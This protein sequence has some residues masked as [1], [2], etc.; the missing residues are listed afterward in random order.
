[1]QRPYLVAANEG[2]IP[3]PSGGPIPINDLV[4]EVFESSEPPM[5][6]RMLNV[7]F[8]RAYAIAPADVR[9]SL[10]EKLMRPLGALSLITLA[11]GVFARIG[12]RGGWPN[13]SVQLEDVQ[14]VRNSDV[15]ALV[16]YVQQVS[17]GTLIE[18]VRMI[19]SAPAMTGSGAAA[20]LISIFLNR[21]IERRK[22]PRG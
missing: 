8:G 17:T 10:L 20:V 14:N 5:K 1:M 2:I 7:L 12:F 4:V 19:E 11:G 9:K 18:A 13:L 22:L 3:E 6:R 16:D 15:I 21:S